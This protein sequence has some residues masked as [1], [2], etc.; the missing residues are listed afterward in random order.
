MASSSSLSQV[1]MYSAKSDLRLGKMIDLMDMKQSV[2]FLKRHVKF[3]G[4][5]RT[6]ESALLVGVMAVVD[7]LVEQRNVDVLVDARGTQ[8]ESEFLTASVR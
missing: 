3:G 5:P 6:G 7:G 8:R 4:A 2:A 1:S